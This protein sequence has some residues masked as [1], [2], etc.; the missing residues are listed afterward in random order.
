MTDQTYKIVIHF[1][2]GNIMAADL[3]TTNSAVDVLIEMAERK[4]FHIPN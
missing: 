2:D 1:L 4:F 3:T